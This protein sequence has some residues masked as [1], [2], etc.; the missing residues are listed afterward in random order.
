MG[1]QQFNQGLQ[2][3]A[4]LIQQN[5]KQQQQQFVAQRANNTAQYLD[6]VQT[7][8][9]SDPTQRAGLEAMRQEFGALI[10][11]DATRG[12]IDSRVTDNQR[13]TL[14]AN[15]FEDQQTERDQRTLVDQ[16]L[17]MAQAGDMA[18]VQKLLADTE[19]L[20]E[21]K[22][23]QSLM[24]VLDAKT[25]REYA[26]EDQQRQNRAETRQ[27][28]QFQ[29]SMAAAAENR[30]LRKINM[31]NAQEERNFRNG[32]RI[33]DDAAEQAKTI[34]NTRLAG[35][36]WANVSTD[37]G[38]DAQALLADLPKGEFDSWLNGNTTDRRQMTK[39]VTEM[40]SSG[41]TLD[42][43][44]KIKVPPA[45]LQQELQAIKGKWW[46]TDNPA[47]DIEDHFRDILSGNAGAANRAKA[48]AAQEIRGQAN[49]VMQTLKRAKTQIG[50]SSALDTSGIVAAL[51][52][53][54]GNKPAG[55]QQNSP[56]LLPEADEDRKLR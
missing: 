17:Q 46:I 12:A 26:A 54:A 30:A 25:R 24:S 33:L 53:L 8:D 23:A 55:A 39:K 38:K 47:T 31:T 1:Q 6:A 18:G 9:L 16:G 7:A 14:V 10:D 44:T 51:A 20:D 15:Q 5:Q 19:F 37:P 27:I 21:G 36:E 11:R 52:E 4:G 40:L 49:N 48:E 50:S 45:L 3:V 56:G 22:V 13:R 35:N 43:G 41:V 28:A 2:A 34:L 29:E 42:D 32:A